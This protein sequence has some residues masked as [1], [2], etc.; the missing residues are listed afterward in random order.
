[1]RCMRAHM[2]IRVSISH[3]SFSARLDVALSWSAKDFATLR[4][5]PAG[6]LSAVC[7][8]DFCVYE[9]RSCYN[10]L[11]LTIDSAT[12]VSAGVTAVSA[13]V[14]FRITAEDEP[15]DGAYGKFVL[16]GTI[17]A[18]AN[19][20]TY[21]VDLA[22]SGTAGNEWKITPKIPKGALATDLD[23]RSFGLKGVLCVHHFAL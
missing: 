8:T 7:C 9:L 4:S 22:P 17:T 5:Q 15:T 11:R 20:Q 13:T 21:N 23:L 14:E 1:M 19:T 12:E 18:A 2:H 6:R 10:S 16:N 3:E